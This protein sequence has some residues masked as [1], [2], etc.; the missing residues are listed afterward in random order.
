MN[1]VERI[2]K[3]YNLAERNASTEEAAA[4]AAKIQE[5]CFKH[6]LELDAVLAQS[7]EKPEPYVR[8]DYLLPNTTRFDV[9]WK[10]TLF[11]A[12]CKA[13]FCKSIYFASTV[14]MAV[15]GQR[16]NFDVAVYEFDYLLTELRR[17]GIESCQRQGFLNNRDKRRYI[18]GFNEGATAT[19]YKKLTAAFTYQSQQTTE[20]RAL[21]VVKD[22]Q[23]EV[24]TKEHFPHLV[25]RSRSI[26]GSSNGYS[27]GR[28]AAQH[29]M[30]NR[31][32]GSTSRG[33]LN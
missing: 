20:S 18:Q 25:H 22:K 30:V 23:L 33:L 17:L 31:G 14:K 8:F 27:D 2:K 13:N 1:I 15:I 16:Q 24:A 3:L 7:G 5:L 11:N 26:G 10:R 29:I 32:V 28:A 12:V 6:N 21:V 4:A 9:G 19:L